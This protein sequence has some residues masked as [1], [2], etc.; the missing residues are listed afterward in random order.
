MTVL[1]LA[2]GP[3]E[4][5]DFRQH[6][7]LVSAENIIGIQVCQMADVH[8]GF[9]SMVWAHNSRSVNVSCVVSVLLSL[10]SFHCL[11]VCLFQLCSQIENRILAMAISFNDCLTEIPT[12]R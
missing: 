7:G 12:L 11:L 2:L 8:V 4:G 3:L 9:L 6:S 5:R 1:P 10:S